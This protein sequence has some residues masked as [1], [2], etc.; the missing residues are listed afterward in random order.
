MLVYIDAIIVH[1]KDIDQN[2]QKVQKVLQCSSMNGIIFKWS[3]CHFF[4]KEICFL[5]HII[6]NG[7]IRPSMEKTKAVRQFPIQTI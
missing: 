2:L 4:K 1:A 3:K 6:G 5:G 7:S